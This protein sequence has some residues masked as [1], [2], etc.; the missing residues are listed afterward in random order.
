M[1]SSAGSL[2]LLL[3]LPTD[4]EGFVVVSVECPSSAEDFL[5]LYLDRGLLL[6]DE[7][8][9]LSEELSGQLSDDDALPCGILVDLPDEER[10]SS[11]EDKYATVPLSES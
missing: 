6:D 8:E 3:G 1:R 10:Y 11:S 4:R 2:A 9:S 5:L 7:N